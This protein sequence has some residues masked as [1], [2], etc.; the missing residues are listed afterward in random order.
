MTATGQCGVDCYLGE[1]GDQQFW[2]TARF[3]HTKDEYEASFYDWGMK[4]AYSVTLYLPL[5]QGVEELWIGVDPDAEVHASTLP[6]SDHPIV[7]YGTSI[8]QGGC[9]SRPGMAYP[10]IM[11]R[12]IPM[13]FVNLGFDGNGKGEP[14]VARVIADIPN[15]ALFVLDYE[16]N[17]LDPLR[18]E[19]TL[20]LFI[21]IL[22]ER[23]PSTPILVISKIRYA[24]ERFDEAAMQT[25]NATKKVQQDIVARL[26]QEGDTEIHFCDGMVL[27]GDDYGDCTVDGGHPTDLG[28]QRMAKSLDPV[29]RTLMRTYL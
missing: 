23:H 1:P 27:L 6:V 15:P 12:S 3:D 13:T 10:N 20:P 29:F 8:T 11:S 16:G 17:V 24:K 25:A 28:F 14:E 22:R 2:S 19:E 21:Q 7:L 18:M 9:A 5:Y 4:K 26:Q